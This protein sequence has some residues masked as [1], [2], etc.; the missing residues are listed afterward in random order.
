MPIPRA[1]LLIE[2]NTGKEHYFQNIA[3][4]YEFLKRSKSY[5]NYYIYS[6]RSEVVCD[7]DG[8]EYYFKVMGQGQRRDAKPERAK[9]PKSPNGLHNLSMQLCWSCARCVGFCS[10]S[11]ELKPVEGWTAKCTTLHHSNAEQKFETASYYITACPLFLKEA[12]TEIER[13]RQREMLIKEEENEK[14]TNCGG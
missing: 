13:K 4:A 6:D 3:E 12:E 11:K 14:E 5:L 9:G 10:W 2:V 1:L 7:I 8:K